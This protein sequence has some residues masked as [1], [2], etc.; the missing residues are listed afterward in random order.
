MRSL[1][2]FNGSI[3]PLLVATFLGWWLAVQLPLRADEPSDLKNPAAL[4]AMLP[5]L[6]SRVDADLA[7]RKPIFP[8]Q[9][10]FEDLTKAPGYSHGVAQLRRVIQDRPQLGRR[11]NE[12][13]PLWIA[14]AYLFGGAK[15]EIR[16]VWSSMFDEAPRNTSIA[17]TRFETLSSPTILV[18][19]KQAG[20]E[21]SP[22]R[23]WSGL[24]FEL[25]NALMHDDVSRSFAAKVRDGSITH[26]EYVLG[27]AR[28]EYNAVRDARL[29]YVTVYLPWAC[30]RGVSSSPSE[31]F[32]ARIRTPQ[33]YLA[34]LTNRRTYPWAY[35]SLQYDRIRV[36]VLYGENRYDEASP[37]FDRIARDGDTTREKV[38]ALYCLGFCKI[39]KKDY[40]SALPLVERAIALETSPHELAKLYYSLA[41]VHHWLGDFEPC[42]VAL[43]KA[44]VM[45]KGGRYQL[46]SLKFQLRLA[47][48]AN[49]EPFLR[50]VCEKY[51]REYPDDD[52]SP[53]VNAFKQRIRR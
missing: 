48:K 8:R 19:G 12:T 17:L 47:A 4:A 5:Q 7:N 52:T 18:A 11:L 51:I 30:E 26:D 9:P 33:E 34:S 22:D 23:V 36:D 41:Q 3:V 37:L 29:F 27:I 49:D 15:T 40:R 2:F 35:Y 44:M 31:W 46:L 45:G 20:S 43:D 53:E 28:E 24:I 50:D 25:H 13:D 16:P 1:H 10:R 32:C 21:L 39:S 38:S 14:T 42:L 6:R